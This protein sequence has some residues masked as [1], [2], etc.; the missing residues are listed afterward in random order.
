[1]V[2]RPFSRRSTHVGPP[3][4]GV[5]LVA[6]A[7][8]L[9]LDKSTVSRRLSVAGAGGWLT[10]LEDRRGRPGRWVVGE[11][12]PERV[13]VLPTVA[14]LLAVANGRATPDDDE[15]AS[16]DDEE[17]DGA[18][19]RVSISGSVARAFTKRALA[20]VAAGRPPCPFCSNPL[21]PQGHICPRANGYRRSA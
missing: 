9:G 1:M 7:G 2:P 12:L 11:A 20:V 8:H 14:R 17:V 13:R 21:D 10:N 19:L 16:Q 15:T 6:V 3:H 4:G 18:I 5:R